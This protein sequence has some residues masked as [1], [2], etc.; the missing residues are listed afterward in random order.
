MRPTFV[1]VLTGLL[2]GT[3]LAGLLNVPGQIVAHQESIPPVRSPHVAKPKKDLVVRVSPELERKLVAKPKPARPRVVTRVV[4]KPVLV[5]TPVAP[6]PEPAPAPAP[7]RKPKPAAKQ[8]PRPA[9]PAPKVV[10]AQPQAPS[11][12]D[13]DDDDDG[14]DDDGGDDHGGGGDD[15]EEDEDD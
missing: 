9:E 8:K 4:L 15:D 14:G 7:P 12:S 13:D 11:S 3:A 6:A 1:H 10:L 2:L 5:R